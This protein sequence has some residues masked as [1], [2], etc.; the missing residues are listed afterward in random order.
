MISRHRTLGR[1]VALLILVGV[2]CRRTDAGALTRRD[3]IADSVATDTVVLVGA[4]DIAECGAGGD[5]ATAALLDDLPGTVFTTGDNAYRRGT[6]EEFVRCYG[7]SWGRQRSRTRPVPGNHD[8]RSA[9][10][11][12][13]YEYF[14]A[15]AGTPGEGY[16]SYDLGA[17]H[18]IALNS[19]IPMKEGSRQ[20]QWLRA[21]LA[22]TEA[23]CVVAYWHHPRFSSGAEHGNDP[24]SS[25]AWQAL[26][27]AG[28]EVILGGHEHNYERFAPQDPD[29]AP[30]SARGIRE[31]VVGT[32][33]AEHYPLGPPLANSEARNGDTWG[34]LKLT[35]YPEGYRWEF[36][37]VA[38]RTFT[39]S[40]AGRC[41]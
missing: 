12:P 31:F 21:D 33:G 36:I 30:D 20:E 23:R 6:A 9:H 4:G 40:G 28:A 16:Y 14:G 24:R 38:G 29:G 22:A 11:G 3:A 8:Y 39:D 15:L 18:V 5:E 35:L 10:G 2:A 26:Y 17:W 19:N 1:T 32:G 25:A 34:V 13:Y 27:D 37:P 7:P 41:H